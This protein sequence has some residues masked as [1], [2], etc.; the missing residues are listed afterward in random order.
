MINVIASTSGWT[1]H[2]QRREHERSLTHCKPRRLQQ[3]EETVE[4]IMMSTVCPF[5]RRET[6]SMTLRSHS[7]DST[8]PLRI[9]VYPLPRLAV[10][11]DSTR[12]GQ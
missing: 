10:Y 7:S 6:T 2:W 11:K 9:P 8:L 1:A 3:C 5:Y 4:I 12:R